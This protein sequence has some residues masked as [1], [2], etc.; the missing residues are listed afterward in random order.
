MPLCDQD[1]LLGVNNRAFDAGTSDVNAQ[2]F[3]LFPPW[4]P[5]SGQRVLAGRTYRQRYAPDV[6]LY[7]ARSGK[8]IQ[9][10]GFVE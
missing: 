5:L 1:A 2:Y 6:R 4:L 3:H 8:L 10:Q 9:H 7:F